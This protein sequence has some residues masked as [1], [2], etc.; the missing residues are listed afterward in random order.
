MKHIFF[1]NM[2]IKTTQKFML[3]LKP[4]G[5]GETM[6]NKYVTEQKRVEK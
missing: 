3:N 2:G 4:V 1:S 6:P 5:K